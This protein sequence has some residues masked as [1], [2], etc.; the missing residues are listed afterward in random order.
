M[1]N[2]TWTVHYIDETG[3]HSAE[4]YPNITAAEVALA[5]LEGEPGERWAS[6]G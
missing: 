5:E 2:T 4:T 6:V 3:T 1:T